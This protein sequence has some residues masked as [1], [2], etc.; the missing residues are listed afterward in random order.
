MDEDSTP[1]EPGHQYGPQHRGWRRQ[2]NE[3]ADKPCNP[4]REYQIRRYAKSRVGYYG[5]GQPLGI[6]GDVTEHEECD[7][8]GYGPA[9]DRQEF[10]SVEHIR[11]LL[12]AA[13]NHIISACRANVA[14]TGRVS[15]RS[16]AAIAQ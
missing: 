9:A 6:S 13:R 12:N 14:R 7:R 11:T 16:I 2:A 1:E 15:T 10:R 8:Q 5:P 4:D 3:G